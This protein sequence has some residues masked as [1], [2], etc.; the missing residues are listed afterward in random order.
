MRTKDSI[1]FGSLF[2]GRSCKSFSR[3][4]SA[5]SS[6]WKRHQR[7]PTGGGNRSIPHDSQSVSNQNNTEQTGA[8]NQPAIDSGNQSSEA[9][10]HQQTQSQP[11]SSTQRH[12][13]RVEA[14]FE[15]QAS[16][17]ALEGRLQGSVPEST[18]NRIRESLSYSLTDFSVTDADVRGVHTQLDR[19]SPADYRATIRRLEGDGLLSRYIDNMD[20]TSRTAFLR[21]AANN[22]YIQR[23][24]GGDPPQ[25]DFHPPGRP[26]MLVNDR[27]LPVSVRDA[28]HEHNQGMYSR[29]S[30]RYSGY[31][32]RYC[33][34]VHRARTGEEIRNLGRPLQIEGA[35][36]PGLQAGDPEYDR[37]ISSWGETYTPSTQA[38]YEAISDRMHDLTNR[39]RPGSFW[40]S[41][42][43]ELGASRRIGDVEF[44]A[45]IQGRAE[46]SDYGATRTTTQ[47]G[48]EV[49]LPNHGVQIGGE[50]GE[51]ITTMPHGV[52]HRSGIEPGASFGLESRGNSIEIENDGTV[53]GQFAPT[54]ETGPYSA[55]SVN[56]QEGYMETGVGISAERENFRGSVQVNVG[57]QGASRVDFEDALTYEGPHQTP[58]ELDQGIQWRDLPAKRREQLERFDYTE[59]EWNRRLSERQR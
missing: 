46:V 8:V 50:T 40:L 14:R 57:L 58:P 16:R 10:S 36:E 43:V 5:V 17:A 23:S 45:G 13:R 6:P 28:I 18:Y 53:G 37:Y 19:L 1:L 15:E 27:S 54:G 51:T 4:S 32:N 21:Q 47:A 20:G 12:S 52:E 48:A 42:E 22:G 11:T 44:E 33:D 25:G 35:Y 38:A 41:G 29:Y 49:S 26:P 34:A 31:L 24:A 59:S 30:E 55:G 3:G 56:V 39:R 7:I 9:I 2:L